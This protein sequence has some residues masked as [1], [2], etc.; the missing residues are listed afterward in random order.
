MT[1]PPSRLRE[2][3][4]LLVGGLIA[5][6][7][8]ALF[9]QITATISPEYFLEGKVRAGRSG[10]FSWRIWLSRIAATLAITLVLCPVIMAALDPIGVREASAGEWS[11]GVATRYLVC[12]GLHVGA[13]L[14]VVIGLFVPGR[15]R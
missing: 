6:V 11:R 1:R 2:Y 5:G 7:C 12:W 15:S 13:Y 10:M 8:G 4:T 9:D 14:G 3:L